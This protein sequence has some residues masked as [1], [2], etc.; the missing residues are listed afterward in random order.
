MVEK[1][2]SFVL[3]RLKEKNLVV[4]KANEENVLK[5]MNEVVLENLRAEDALDR[6]VEEMIQSHA[7]ALDSD[8]I[9]YRKMF[10]MVKNKLAKEKGFVL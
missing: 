7:G 1:L 6:E 5:K 4:L 8:S 9:D 10:S 2:T 3:S